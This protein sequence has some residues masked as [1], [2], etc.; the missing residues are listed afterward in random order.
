MAA[1]YALDQPLRLPTVRKAATMP[2]V[3][4]VS[5]TDEDLLE[6]VG[7][8]DRGAFEVLYKRYS[9]SV[10]GLALRRSTRNARRELQTRLASRITRRSLRMPARRRSISSSISVR[11]SVLFSPAETQR[12]A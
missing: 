9:R 4:A 7:R 2:D 6:R 5:P 12:K 8:R 1:D 10:L 3:S 11:S